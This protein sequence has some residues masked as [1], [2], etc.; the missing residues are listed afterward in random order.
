MESITIR[1][2]DG[3]KFTLFS[4]HTLGIMAQLTSRTIMTKK[5]TS[6]NNNSKIKLKL[7]FSHSGVDII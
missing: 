5:F 4:H 3:N 2:H 1:I 7:V 6:N